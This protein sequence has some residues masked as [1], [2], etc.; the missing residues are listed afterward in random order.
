M[1]KYFNPRMENPKPYKAIY[2][3]L[4]AKNNGNKYSNRKDKQNRI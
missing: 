2:T 4:S 1:N 3:I